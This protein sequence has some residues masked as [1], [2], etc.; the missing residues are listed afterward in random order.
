MEEAGYRAALDC[1]VL[2]SCVDRPW[3][4]AILNF[5]AYAHLI[6]V[7]DGGLK[8]VS[9]KDRYGL[10]RADWRAHIV[11]SGRR[12]LECLGQYDPGLVSAERD[13]YLDDPRYIEGL[14]NDHEAKRNENVFGFSL[15]V[16]S[17]EILQ[18][19]AMVVA[20][21]GLSYQGAQNYHFVTGILDSDWQKKCD[22]GCPY[23]EMVGLGD[24]SGFELTGNHILAEKKRQERVEAQHRRRARDVS[25]WKRILSRLFRR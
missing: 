21:L 24:R 22:S 18:F 23:P 14:P 15:S 25:L 16:A 2:F 17:F 7:V 1:D 4:R 10:K 11:T 3:P 20:P 9:Q 13:G 6:P 19:I 12:C 5:I 8:I